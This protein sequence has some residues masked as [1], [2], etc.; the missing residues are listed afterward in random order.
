MGQ[1]FTHKNVLLL[2]HSNISDNFGVCTKTMSQK[3][4]FITKFI[5]MQVDKSPAFKLD[6]NQKA[7]KYQSDSFKI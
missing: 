2:H 1:V 7:N 6:C 4:R 5:E 3:Y